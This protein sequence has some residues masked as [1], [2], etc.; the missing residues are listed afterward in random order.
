MITTAHPLNKLIRFE[1]AYWIPEPN[2]SLGDLMVSVYGLYPSDG[3]Y[4]QT[5]LD[6]I[7]TLNPL[8]KNQYVPLGKTVIRL[9]DVQT[10]NL[11]HLLCSDP[12]K[13]IWQLENDFRSINPTIK[14]V[15]LHLP[16]KPKEIESFRT[17][18]GMLE[19]FEMS[20]NLTG[21]GIGMLGNVA[22]SPLQK[23][24]KQQLV[25]LDQYNRKM[26]S[27][28]HYRALQQQGLKSMNKALGWTDK[29]LFGGKTAKQVLYTKESHGLKTHRKLVHALE[30]ISKL[31]KYSSH[32]GVL[33]TGLGIMTSCAK[34]SSAEAAKKTEVAYEEIGATL[35]GLIGGAS[36]GF[37]LLT[38]TNPLGWGVGLV[39][40]TVAGFGSSAATSALANVIYQNAGDF[41]DLQS[42]A[43]VAKWCK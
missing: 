24:I 7:R 36:V 27:L 31:S 17:L 39:L 5:L 18:L 33:L 6:Y 38:L 35:G 28:Q 12:S 41:M 30:N 4:Y 10:L 25:L 40:S 43:L 26:I 9:V 19:H 16:D 29:Y 13:V 15:E 11:D 42:S 8:V 34:I 20:N 3:V 37:Y 22:G 1:P 21:V 23:E 32:A 2:Q 14:E